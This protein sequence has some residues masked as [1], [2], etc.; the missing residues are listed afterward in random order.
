V[1][2]GRGEGRR[3]RIAIVV[4][5]IVVVI[6]TVVHAAR[7]TVPTAILITAWHGIV[8]RPV[9]IGSLR[10]TDDSLRSGSRRPTAVHNNPTATK[11]C[12]QRASE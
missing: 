9:A 6:V 11:E 12:A 8:Q 4:I 1:R 7:C 10:K 5:V 3:F 2:A